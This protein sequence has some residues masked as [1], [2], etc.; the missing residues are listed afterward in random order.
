VGEQSSVGKCPTME[1]LHA[2]LDV[3]QAFQ[4]SP[5]LDHLALQNDAE[6]SLVR[7][8]AWRQL[9]RDRSADALSL[10]TGRRFPQH[11]EARLAM[12]RIVLSNSGGFWFWRYLERSKDLPLDTPQETAGFMSLRAMWLG[13]LRDESAA[14]AMQ[15]QALALVNDDPWLW[16]ERSYLLDRLDRHEQALDAAQHALRLC[17]EYRTGLLQVARL[18]QVLKRPDEAAHLLTTAHART[19]NGAMAWQMFSLVF[20]RSQPEEALNWLQE[21]ERSLPLADKSWR[22]ALAA[23]RADTYLQLNQIALARE[24]AASVPGKG[25][26]ANLAKRLAEVPAQDDSEPIPRALLSLT[27]VQQHW[28]TCAPATLTALAAYWGKPADHVEV[29]QAICYDG[30][31][32]ASERNWARSQGFEVSEFKLNWATAVALIDA[33]VPFALATQ[34]VGGGHLQAVVGVDRLRETLL[35]RD[36]AQ[37]LHVEYAAEGLFAQQQAGGPRAMVM[38]PPDEAWRLHGIDLPEKELWDLGHAVLDAQQRHDRMAALAALAELERVAPDSDAAWRA[39]RHMAIYDGDEP[40]I[41]VATEKL[42]E[43]YPEDTS[44]QLSR[45]HS[46]YEVQGQLAGDA[47]LADLAQRPSPDPALLLRWSRHLRLDP[48]RRLMA[49]FAARRSLWRDRGGGRAWF[50]WAE[51]CWENAGALASL[52]P[53]RWASTL[54]PTEEWVASSYAK[55]CRVAGQSEQGL[56]WLRER[57]KVWGDRS[58]APALTL[59]EGLDALQRDHEADLELQAALQRRPQDDGLRLSM[60]ERALFAGHRAR[61]IQ[62]L[63]ACTSA[64]AP[65]LLRVSALLHEAEGELDLALER[66]HEAVDQEPFNL[67]LHRL[68]LRVLRRQHG[69]AE[70]LQRW[71][72][73]AEAHPAHWGLQ[74]LL[75][76][77]TPDRPDQVNAQLAHLQA[78]HPTVPWLQRERAI[79]A[80]RQSRLDEA[81][82]LA[83]HAFELAPHQAASHYVLA[84]CNQ[85]KSGYVAAVPHLK[86]AISRDAEYS[87][88]VQSLLNAPEAEQVRKAV[89]FIAT[90]LRRQPLLGDGL[91]LFQAEAHRGWSPQEVLDLLVELQGRWPTLWQAPVAVSLQLQRMQRVE[92]SLE[93]LTAAV[94]R[95][96]ALPR[97]HLEVAESLRLLGRVE[98]ARAS[99]AK[100]LELSPGWNRAVRMQVDL[101]HGWGRDLEGA[102]AVLKRALQTRDAW[103]DADLIGLLAWVYLQRERHDEALV[104]V[105][106]SLCLDPSATWVWRIAASLTNQ[107]EAPAVFDALIQ[108]VIASRPGDPAVWLVSAQHERDAA[109]ALSAAERAIELQ[110]LNEAAWLARFERLETLG[111]L[112]DIER[113]L[114][115]LPWPS[116]APTGVRS[117]AAKLKWTQGH[118]TE[119]I[120][121]LRDLQREAPHDL[122]LCLQLADWLDV[123]DDH[124]GYLEQAE[125]MQ[126]LAPHEARSHAYLGHALLK[127]N[128]PA[129]ALLPLKRA[130]DLSPD[131]AFAARQLVKAAMAT[132]APDEAEPAL[133]A[134]WQHSKDVATACE[135]LEISLEVRQPAKTLEWFQR[136]LEVESFDIDRSKAALERCRAS[137]SWPDMA[138]LQHKGLVN[139]A[140]PLGLAM[141]WVEHECGGRYFSTLWAGW[142]MQAKAQGPYIGIALMR[143]MVA[144]QAGLPL[145]FFIRRFE[146]TL[147][148]DPNLWGEVSYALIQLSLHRRVVDWLGDWTSRD[149]P[150]LFALS[151]LAGCLVVL[152]SWVELEKVVKAMLERSPNYED[153]RLWQMLLAARKGALQDLA[154]LLDRCH[155]WSPDPWMQDVLKGLRHFLDAARSRC[156]GPSVLRFRHTYFAGTDTQ[157]ARAALAELRHLLVWRHTPW[158]KLWRWL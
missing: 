6:A 123:H 41:L 97:L 131:Y 83:Q 5:W 115:L 101:L 133:Q 32:Q 7:V 26:Y 62:L 142:Q 84:Y 145:R 28:M 112:G 54:Q 85:R 113:L 10:V 74:S 53:Y 130:L 23:R 106:R 34:Y 52:E 122:A 60:A 114:D 136:L 29:A 128:R 22:G 147:R 27:M 119:A 45:L 61:A 31:P 50:E 140:G 103:S 137:E 38:L 109:K 51:L 67:S 46:L 144:R 96:P 56:L 93:M 57:N 153:A 149:R 92:Q 82:V 36:P 76:E 4:V 108:E 146:P 105:R 63:S 1:T 102:E 66:V 73:L 117:W 33:G 59:A 132:G 68:L 157:Q 139:G 13:G 78:F 70:A 69:D 124:A 71:R 20:D 58:G 65:A 99:A 154:D 64:K 48:A 107:A 19:S 8:R 30:T 94:E 152:K 77:A 138:V 111:R 98:D 87:N 11:A 86:A 9:G 3:G 116:P 39:R 75:Y 44:L 125:L 120:H 47:W 21:T 148:A 121:C 134:L 104:E 129:P 143:W 35:V 91:L 155:E 24:Q 88:P 89:D 126:G 158:T 12:L 100:A 25:F 43:R 127:S 14:L 37:A 79:Q 42:L 135:G 16:V 95:F 81:I 141:D 49:E 15:D 17:P 2:W 110:P 55:V 150:P 118:F 90:E 40:T 80:A 151:N 72:P 18:L 156:D